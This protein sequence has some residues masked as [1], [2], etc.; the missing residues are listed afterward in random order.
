MLR[1]FQVGFS[2]EPCFPEAVVPP[3]KRISASSTDD[4][5]VQESY[6][7]SGSSFPE[8]PGEPDIRSTGRGIS[9]GMVVWVITYNVSAAYILMSFA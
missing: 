2:K 9:A 6:I 8:L 4:N 3:A 1:F 7:H 5:M